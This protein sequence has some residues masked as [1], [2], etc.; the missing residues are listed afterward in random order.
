MV[1]NVDDSGFRDLSPGDDGIVESV[2]GD[3]PDSKRLA[4]L[5]FVRGAR[6]TMLRPGSPCI[7]RIDGRCVGLGTGHQRSIRLTSE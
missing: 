3:R 1:I 2:R 6:V 7:I 4:D 5:G